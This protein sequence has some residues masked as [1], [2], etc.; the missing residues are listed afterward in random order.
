MPESA[1][2]RPTKGHEYVF[3]L[4]KRSRYYFDQ[5]AV[6]EPA[7]WARWGKQTTPKYQGTRTAAG[8]MRPR[9]KAELEAIR[10]PQSRRAWELFEK[11]GLTDAHL[12]AIRAVGIT[13]TGKAQHT[14]EGLGKNVADVVVLAEEAKAALGGYYRE[15]LVPALGRNVRSVWEIATQPFPGAHFAT[16]PEAL[17]RRCLLAGCPEQ[18]CATCGLP[19]TRQTRVSYV[20]SPIHGEG[21]V[22]GSR[23]VAAQP[24]HLT[25][26][27][28]NKV[29]VSGQPRFSK[30]VMTL[31]W[32]DCGHGAY[33]PGLVLDP[34]FGA[35][36]TGVVAESLGRD[37][38]GVELSPSYV[39]LARRR[40]EAARAGRTRGGPAR[41]PQGGRP[42]R[43]ERAGTRAASSDR[44][45]RR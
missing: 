33:R 32:R 34:F 14:Q 21:S 38:L 15:F 16:F 19:R 26:G 6:R 5:E 12:D 3:L 29:G 11:H 1:R 40:L 10:R 43:S 13:D 27:R 17:V 36:T 22:H 37:W 18:V 30:R 41:R 20:K 25:G 44:S 35:G 2:D 7:E 23:G 45:T 42:T 8:W 4:A 31:G 24:T 39:A 9:T 28:A